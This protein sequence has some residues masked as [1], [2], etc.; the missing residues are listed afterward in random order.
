VTIRALAGIVCLNLAYAVVG[1]SLLWGLR[2][3]RTWGDVGLL[4]GLGYLVGLSAFGVLWTV[5]LVLGVP[6]GGASLVLVLVALA[7]IGVAVGVVRGVPRPKGRPRLGG[8]PMVL[9]SAAGVALSALFLE[10]VFRAGRLQS[11]QEYDAWAFWVPK[12]KAIFFF[13]GLDEQVFTTT[14]APFYPPLQPILDAAAFHAMGGVDVVTLHIQFWFVLVGFVWAAAGLLHRHVAAWL[15]WPPLVLVLVVPRYG[16]RLLAPQAD[17]LVDV[18]IVIAA[19][20]LALWLRD[21]AGWRVA[22]SAILLAGAVNTKREGILFS[23]GVLL[24]A[25]VASRPRRWPALAVAAVAVGLTMVPW[26]IWTA[27]HDLP[28]GAPS[29]SFGGDR[30]RAALDVSFDVLYSTALWSVLPLVATIA[31]GAAAVWGDRRLTAYVGVLALVLFAGGVW[32][33]AGIQ[34]FSLSADESG[35]PIVRLTG[36]IVLLAAV[37]TPLLLTSVWRRGAEP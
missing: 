21:R 14:A 30:L 18:F 23:A 9:V 13:D 29:S 24:A 20:S 12:G 7:V 27:R 22:A 15:L 31:L 17:V 34:E 11:L 10:A 25:F 35:N 32:S 5:L 26:R 36:S 16:E 28:A 33:T 37:A 2:A 4:A 8:T 3:L 6:F 19:L 1:L